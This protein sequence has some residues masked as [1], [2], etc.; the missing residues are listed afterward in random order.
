M[1][2]SKAQFFNPKSLKS[3]ATHGMLMDSIDEQC[4]GAVRLL[5]NDC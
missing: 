1:H 4:K 3:Q 2:I 5:V